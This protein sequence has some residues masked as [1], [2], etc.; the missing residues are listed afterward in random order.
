MMA[1]RATAEA[2]LRAGRMTRILAGP[3]FVCLALAGCGDG[4]PAPKAPNSS[5]AA[6]AAAPSAPIGDLVRVRLETDA[7]PIVLELDHRHAPITTEN[8]IHYVDQHRFDNSV[9]YR[10]S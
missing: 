8:F 1:P 7:G 3:V 2:S 4:A 10:S 6:N 9:F 5:A